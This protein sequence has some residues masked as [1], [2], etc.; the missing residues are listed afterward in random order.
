MAETL[1]ELFNNLKDI[2]CPD[3][4]YIPSNHLFTPIIHRNVKYT[5]TECVD[6]EHSIYG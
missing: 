1:S 4:E 6:E 2:D 5:I 3:E